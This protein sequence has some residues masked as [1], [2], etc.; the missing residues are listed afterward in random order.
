MTFPLCSQCGR[1][2]TRRKDGICTRCARRNRYR[3][4]PA[5][6]DTVREKT[7]QTSRVKRAARPQHF[8]PP[9]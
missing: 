7:R 8:T 4:D 2:T 5:F 9:K 1:H 3:D 6:A